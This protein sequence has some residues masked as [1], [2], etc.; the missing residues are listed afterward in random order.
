MPGRSPSGS[1][2]EF[3]NVRLDIDKRVVTVDGTEVHLTPIEYELF[4]ELPLDAGRA[5]THRRLL[6]RVWGELYE[7]EVHYL[8]PVVNALRRK[9]GTQ[10]IRTEPGVGYRR[11]STS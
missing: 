6:K 11:R 5:L 8:R 3:G 1:V 10:L 7:D 9:L 4:K 2:R